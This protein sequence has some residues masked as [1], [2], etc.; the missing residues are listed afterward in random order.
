[1]DQLASVRAAHRNIPVDLQDF[2]PLQFLP[3]HQVA[4]H[5]P[6]RSSTFLKPY[7]LTLHLCHLLCAIKAHHTTFLH[8]TFTCHQ[9]MTLPRVSHQPVRLMLLTHPC[10]HFL[11]HPIQ[12]PVCVN[13]FLN[14]HRQRKWM[15][16]PVETYF[17]KTVKLLKIR[18]KIQVP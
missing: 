16:G 10:P 12:S 14:Y 6:I 1:M 18:P 11:L 9:S 13:H 2:C 17:M 4:L 15:Y 3:L 7:L 8:H 5:H